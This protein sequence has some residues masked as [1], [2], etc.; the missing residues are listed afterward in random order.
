MA[1]HIV[2]DLVM[3]SLIELNSLTGVK[4]HPIRTQ[5]EPSYC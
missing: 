5:G 3:F 1:A 2:V 4:K